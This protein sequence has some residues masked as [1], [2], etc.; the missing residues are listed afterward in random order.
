VE[1]SFFFSGLNGNG[2]MIMACMGW[3]ANMDIE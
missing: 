3:G 2:M 1:I